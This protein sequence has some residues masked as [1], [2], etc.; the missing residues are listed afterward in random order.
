[1]YYTEVLKLCGFED[2]E[3]ER[4]KPRLDKAFKKLESCGKE[5]YGFD[6]IRYWQGAYRALKKVYEDYPQ[7]VYKE[8]EGELKK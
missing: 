5:E 8:I 7:D 4:E 6:K 3:I 2:A 1:M